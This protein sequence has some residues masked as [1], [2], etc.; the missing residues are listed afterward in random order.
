MARSRTRHTPR[1]PA[2]AA[3]LAVGA[4]LVATASARLILTRQAAVAR[5]RIGKPLGEIP[6]DADR[7]WRPKRGGTPVELLMVGDSIAAGLGA[8]RPKDVL[9][10]RIAKSVAGFLQRPV[11]LRT[12]AQVG[13]ESQ[14]LARQI[15]WLPETYR[16]DVA[17]VIV[18]GNDVTHRVPVASAAAD[19]ADAITRLRARG[20]EVVVGTCPDLGALRAV[21]Q[22]LRSLGAQ[23]SRQLARAQAVAGERAGARVV[24][25][26]RA[27]GHLF[28]AHPDDMFSIDRF[29]PSALGYRRTADALAPEVVA[30]LA[31]AA[32]APTDAP[33]TPVA[34]ASPATRAQNVR[35]TLHVRTTLPQ[36]G[37]A[38][39]IEL[40][41]AQVE[42]LGGGKRA[43][44]VVRIGERVARL[45]LGVMGGKNLIGMSKAA[46]A[47]LGVEIGDTV[48]ASID[49]DSA[50]REIT[51]PD[52]L[53]A[54]LDADG[55]RAAFDA[56]APSRRKEIVRGVTEAKQ[57]ATR[58]RR[59]AAAVD[60]L[61]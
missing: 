36:N 4:V 50:E 11:R 53:A 24:S 59:I 49:L 6:L 14:D 16:P 17:V 44:V 61:G 20:A 2:L 34:L 40:T 5:R 15:D 30:A 9:G 21:P 22:P 43:A 60:S 52:D 45:R 1:T 56:L 29:H 54:A 51:V 28:V 18:G 32:S 13:A 39:A 26:R 23:A 19:L 48:E 35:M 10:A 8:E 58:E 25:L 57:A 46:R 31:G 37:P 33:S 12:A 7:V 41:D 38:T 42:E 47:E 27:V 55:L 3:G